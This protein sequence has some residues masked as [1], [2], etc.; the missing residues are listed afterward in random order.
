MKIG[1]LFK[2]T[3]KRKKLTRKIILVDSVDSTNNYLRE[4]PDD[5]IDMTVV[6]AA[7]QTAGRGQGANK[8]ESNRGENLLFSIRIHPTMMRIDQ[9]FLLSEAGALALLEVLRSLPEAAELPERFTLKWP[10]DIYYGNNKLSGTLIETTVTSR[11]MQSCIFGVGLNVN[12]DSFE[13]DA[14]NPISLK[15]I[16]GRE[17]DRKSI[18]NNVIASFEKY[19]T[20][21]IDGRYAE[22]AAM[23]QQN[24]FHGDG[25]HT[26]RNRGGEFKGSI[27]EVEDNG[28]LVLR[29]REGKIHEFAF[30]EIEFVV[31]S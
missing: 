31:N 21:I 29:D 2:R 23:Y 9:Q 27:V 3:S 22:I 25:F 11:G 16:F 30:K 14:P 24:L 28:L 1:Q 6:S 17:F 7:F 15:Q 18:L 19:Y 4:L 8:W 20:M 26:Y 10:N 12:Q 5:D 13:S